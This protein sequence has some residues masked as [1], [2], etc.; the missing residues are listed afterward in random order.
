M[1]WAWAA[2]L[3]WL[4]TAILGAVITVVTAMMIITIHIAAVLAVMGFLL[5]FMFMGGIWFWRSAVV[6]LL[7]SVYA[8]GLLVSAVA[9][10][11]G[12]SPGLLLLLG[13]GSISGMA[14]R[15]LNRTSVAPAS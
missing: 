15:E 1:S 11:A 5:P 12:P 14:A 4:V 13:I 2:G 9:V 6:A 10:G 8:F 7:A 3:I